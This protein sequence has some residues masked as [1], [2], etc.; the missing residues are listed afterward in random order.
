MEAA[1]TAKRLGFCRFLFLCSNNRVV[2]TCNSLYSNR[3]QDMVM[4]ADLRTL[5][6]QGFVCKALHVSRAI[7]GSVFCIADLAA[8]IPGNHSWIILELL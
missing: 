1:L 4:V 6:H 3:W 2:Q 8:T 7:L 5:K